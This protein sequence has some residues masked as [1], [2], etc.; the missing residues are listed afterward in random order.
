MNTPTSI[1]YEERSVHLPADH[2]RVNIDEVESVIF[3]AS[4]DGST[5]ST[6]LLFFEPGDRREFAADER[7][8][9]MIVLEGQIQ[10][11]AGSFTAG[12]FARI[13]PAGQTFTITS[14]TKAV[15]FHKLLPLRPGTAETDVIRVNF[16]T[17]A[18]SRGLVEGLSVLG[19]H[20]NDHEGTALVHWAPGTVFN[21]HTHPG[22]EEIFVLQGTFSDEHGDYPAGAWLRN[23]P[24]SSHKPFSNEGTLIY[25]KTGHLTQS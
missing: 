21:P 22:G 12:E 5:Q 6:E 20:N 2:A 24:W 14:D 8:R 10:T 13:P 4:V 15:L 16:Q 19:L 11:D 9:E 18:W 1:N 25:V 7:V 23:P 3:D 17:A